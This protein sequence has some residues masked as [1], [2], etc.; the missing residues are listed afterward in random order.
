MR[1]DPDCASTVDWN[2][3]PV[4]CRIRHVFTSPGHNYFGHHEKP[5]GEHP[6]EERERIELV[7]GRG[8]RG[9]R[10]FDHKENYK[11]QVTLLDMTVVEAVR[12]FAGQPELPA[13]VFRRNVVVSGVDLNAWIG[14]RFRI[15]D[16]LLEG[17]EECRPCY[18]MDRACGRPGTEELMKGQGGLRCRI[19]ESG[20]LRPDEVKWEEVA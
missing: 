9:D 8:I 5:P 20:F 13:A 6:M 3:G 16:V 4:N 14:K 15:G 12:G 19:V 17:C 7:A 1:A 10:F 11:G 2:D 18:W